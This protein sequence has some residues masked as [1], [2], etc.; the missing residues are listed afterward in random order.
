MPRYSAKQIWRDN[1][2]GPLSARISAGAQQFA[3]FTSIVSGTATATVSTAVVRSGSI[4]LATARTVATINSG[5]GLR[6]FEV[7][8]IT[9]GTSFIIGTN[10]GQGVARTTTIQWIIFQ[11]D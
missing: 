5:T 9:D 3:G 11:T 2:R 4:V 8:S 10:D 6:Q 7:Q 1:L